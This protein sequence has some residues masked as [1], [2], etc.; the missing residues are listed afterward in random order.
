[1]L[2]TCQ[3]TNFLH[4][5]RQTAHLTPYL[6]SA[7]KGYTTC[8]HVS[9]CQSSKTPTNSSKILQHHHLRAKGPRARLLT[10]RSTPTSHHITR[11]KRIEDTNPKTSR[12]LGLSNPPTWQETPQST[13][14]A[15]PG[16]LPT[17]HDLHPSRLLH[18]LHQ[19]LQRAIRCPHPLA[20]TYGQ[21]RHELSGKYGTPKKVALDQT[22][23]ITAYFTDFDFA[24]TL[25]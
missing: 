19:T 12:P 4:F 11:N 17:Q 8:L 23:P 22:L 13:L 21:I 14:L 3:L 24:P 10:N 25:Q 6:A 2:A 15:L 9:Q 5:T 20:N 1:M 16:E 7:S 18:H